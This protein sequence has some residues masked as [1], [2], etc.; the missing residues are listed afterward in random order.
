MLHTKIKALPFP[1][2]EKKNFEVGLP[3]SDVPTCDPRVGML[4]TAE[5]AIWHPRDALTPSPLLPKH[6]SFLFYIPATQV[7]QLFTKPQNLSL[8]PIESICK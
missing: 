5:G 4:T 1:V 3:C 2:S 8:V 7:Y 6:G